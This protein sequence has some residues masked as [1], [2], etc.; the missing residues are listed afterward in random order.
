MDITSLLGS[1]LGDS[2]LEAIGK[3]TNTD[4]S[5]VTNVLKSA[6]PKLL[7]GASKQAAS[8]TNKE[9]FEEA[10][11]TH[12]KDR[13]SSVAS[14]LK[15]VDLEDGAKI[16]KH[17]IGGTSATATKEISKFLENDYNK[18][19]ITIK[20]DGIHY[21][22]IININYDILKHFE[23]TGKKIGVDINSNKN[24][25]IVTSDGVKEHFDVNHENKMIKY[26]NQLISPCRKKLSRKKKELLKRLQKQYNKRTNKLQDYIEKLSYNLVKKYDVIVFEYS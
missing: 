11:A 5:D 1:F 17:L 14:F 2:S 23:L 10:L 22:A 12:A 26:L 9:G 7:E 3:V 4:T 15:K 25:W 18:D 20:Y 6:L 21:Y 8:K 19:D 24:G 13:I 16:V